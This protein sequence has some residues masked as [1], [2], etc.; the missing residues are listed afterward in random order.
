MTDFN[1]KDE[2]LDELLDEAL[3]EELEDISIPE[4]TENPPAD[5]QEM[6]VSVEE[7]EIDID[8][9]TE[10]ITSRSYAKIREMLEPLPAIDIADIFA[11]LE[12]R[13]RALLF[14]IMPKEMGRPDCGRRLSIH[15]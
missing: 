14:R 5:E 4:E 1:E 6:L 13:H 7:I 9:L 15:F 8:Q 12:A 11:E 3:T 2:L 10:L